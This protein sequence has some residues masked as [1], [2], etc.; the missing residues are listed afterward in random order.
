MVIIV[1]YIVERPLGIKV[2][3]IVV[4][5]PKI[6]HWA[7]LIEEEMMKKKT[8]VGW[9]HRSAFSEFRFS[10]DVFGHIVSTPEIYRAKKEKEWTPESYPIKKVRITIEE[11]K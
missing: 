11:I 8:L 9:I 3:V 1:V 4:G 7:R 6:K 10:S 2:A 5:M